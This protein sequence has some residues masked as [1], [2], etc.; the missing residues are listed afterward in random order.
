[1]RSFLI[2]LSTF[3]CVLVSS[4]LTSN[5][6]I[7]NADEAPG[8][9]KSAKDAL[10]QTISVIR[11]STA[12]AIIKANAKAKAKV[13]N[14]APTFAFSLKPRTFTCPA[15]GSI[16]TSGSVEGSRVAPRSSSAN[17][18]LSLNDCNGVNG[19]LNGLIRGALSK[20][21]ARTSTT[22]KG[23]VAIACP[24]G[25]AGNADID[26][27]FEGNVTYSNQTALGTI[28]GTVEGRCGENL[29]LLECSWDKVNIRNKEALKAGCGGLGMP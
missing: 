29:V 27:V 4:F 25:L 12:E 7:A 17:V 3:L 8:L 2:T 24:L 14:R 26:I 6:A 9:N 11:K 28:S 1:M 23:N 18:N 10:T 21:S 22:L 13:A 5:I 15:T 19:S 20:S 16:S